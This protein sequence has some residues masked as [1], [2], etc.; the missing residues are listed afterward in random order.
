MNKTLENL[1]KEIDILDEE[2][3]NI[4]AKRM[5]IVYKVGK[6]KKEQ[7]IPPLDKTRWQQIVDRIIET[8]KKKNIPETSVK[9]IYEEIH[10]AA[11]SLEKNL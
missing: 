1:R 9:I 8:A 2:L 4:L 6:L 7:G 11:L 3:L 5:D 10:K